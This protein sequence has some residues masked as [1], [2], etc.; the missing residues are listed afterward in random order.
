[1][2]AN[3]CRL[4]DAEGEASG[5]GGPPLG[6]VHADGVGDTLAIDLITGAPRGHVCVLPGVHGSW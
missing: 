2:V 4:R 1:M 3:V 5:A 6:A